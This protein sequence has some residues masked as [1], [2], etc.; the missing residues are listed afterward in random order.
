[1]NKLKSE[2]SLNQQITYSAM[3]MDPKN[4]PEF[5]IPEQQ[6]AIE[7]GKVIQI[8]MKEGRIR[9]ISLDQDGLVKVDLES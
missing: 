9:T 5:N 8:M 4:I 2:L 6:E 3:M 1:M 7:I